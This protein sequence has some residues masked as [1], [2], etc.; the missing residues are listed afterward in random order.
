[1]QNY[2]MSTKVTR[3][4]VE[5]K[6]ENVLRTSEYLRKVLTFENRNYRLWK[7]T[8]SQCCRPGWCRC[9][10]RVTRAR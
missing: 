10:E 6:L 5:L 7:L 2:I 9:R 4:Y 8:L 1:M 3:A